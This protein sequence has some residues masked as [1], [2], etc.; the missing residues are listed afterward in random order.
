MYYNLSG[1]DMDEN[2][3]P[4]VP[5]VCENAVTDLL[6]TGKFEN[7]VFL[8][9]QFRPEWC[10]HWSLMEGWW[11]VS[12]RLIPRA[13]EDYLT[14]LATEDPEIKA[15]AAKH[16]IEISRFTLN[17]DP[18]VPQWKFEYSLEGRNRSIEPVLRDLMATGKF[19]KYVGGFEMV[20]ISSCPNPVSLNDS[21][22]QSVPD[23]RWPL[24]MIQAPCAW[25]ISTGNNMEIGIA[26]TEFDT[27]HE[28]LKGKFTSVSGTPVSSP[29]THG[30]L[31]SSVAAAIPNNGKGMAGVGYNAT[32]AAG[33][34][35]HQVGVLTPG[36][37]IKAAINNLAGSSVINV[38]WYTTGLDKTEAKEFTQSG[39]TLVLAGGNDPGSTDHSVIAD[40]PGVIVVSSVDK[41]NE[42]G[43][44][45][46]AN[47]QWTDICAPGKNI[48][49]ATPGNNGYT[50]NSGT[51][52]AA[53]FVAGTIALMLD[54]N[55]YLNLMP[56]QVEE[57][58][59]YTA[60]PVKGTPMQSGAGR[61]NA[62]KAVSVPYLYSPDK[63]VCTAGSSFTLFNPPSGI[64]WTVSDPTLFSVDYP[65]SNPAVV[66]RIGSGN[67]SATLYARSGGANGAIIASMSITACAIQLPKPV[68]SG[69]TTRLCSGSSATY[70]VSNAPSGF[71]W[72]KSSNLNI[73]SSSTGS[74]TV[75]ATSNSGL[76][77][78]A[79]MSGATELA[80]KEVWVGVPI[81]EIEGP[82]SVL[83]SGTFYASH[84]YYSNPT[85]FQW[86][87][88]GA[89]PYYY[90]ISGNGSSEISIT[91]YYEAQY[92]LW[93]DVT[94]SCGTFYG[95]DPAYKGC[96]CLRIISESGFLLS[97]PRFR[98]SSFGY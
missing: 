17:P 35:Q 85:N 95:Y 2:W 56:A 84:N 29:A 36:N 65:S 51:S 82:S 79:V 59:K 75:T 48:R 74:I 61:L 87:L 4:R 52:L 33:I 55:K 24:D 81:I 69:A 28:D 40:I 7:F 6:A 58:L 45:G 19:E 66:R 50:I 92:Q 93:A 11:V 3:R 98:Y 73:S 21:W 16:G 78:V 39:T 13:D 72:S 46:H 15:L 97:Q 10:S 34:V 8:Y 37:N 25:T 18:I 67:G 77:W 76:G 22:Y 42:N 88:A 27:Q 5:I 86:A 70:T 44:T 43:P 49:V 23:D 63:E 12:I 83:S 60:D 89:P 90:D 41:N 31:V 14:Y 96:I 20:G 57:I 80:R 9:E 64:C 91:F 68:I 62:Y 32:I 94:N 38:S 71:T 53:P 54:V 47:N 30:T 26:D 1:T